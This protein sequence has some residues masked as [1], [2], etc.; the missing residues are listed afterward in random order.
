ML[1]SLPG[2]KLTFRQFV[3]DG[4]SAT[5][6]LPGLKCGADLAECL[7]PSFSE[8]AFTVAPFS[9]QVRTRIASMRDKIV[10]R[11]TGGQSSMDAALIGSSSLP[12][13]K[14]LAV[15]SSI[16]GGDRIT[17]DYA[18]AALFW[19]SFQR[20]GRKHPGAHS[21]DAGHGLFQ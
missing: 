11:D 16:P 14:M 18:Q 9:R 21:G 6:N 2:G 15:S 4:A 3:G 20:Y 19:L 17:E 8:S 13:W 10:N 12:V 5:V 1:C 7:T